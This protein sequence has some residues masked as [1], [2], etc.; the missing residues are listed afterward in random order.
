VS[1]ERPLVFITVGTDHH[2]FDRL[3]RWSDRWLAANRA[4]AGFMQTG[5][6]ARPEHVESADYLGY[7]E[8]ETTMRRAVA[9]VT[10]GGPGS[11]MLCASLGTRPIVVPREARLG[12]HVDDHQLVFSRRMAQQGSIELAESEDRL[13]ELLSMAVSTGPFGSRPGERD[14]VARAVRRVELL[15]NELMG[16]PALDRV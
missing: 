1:A 12:E 5:T 14:H 8:M 13:G 4:A 16:G 3:V 11:I 15:V 6:S 7:E 10:H 2:R 9:V